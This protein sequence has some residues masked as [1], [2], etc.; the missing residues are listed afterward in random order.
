M[1]TFVRPVLVDTT[2]LVPLA[3]DVN[4][5]VLAPE[6][7]RLVLHHRIVYVPKIRAVVRTGLKQLEQLVLHTILICV[8]LA[9][10]NITTRVTRVLDVNL[11]AREHDKP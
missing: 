8:Q 6:K 7:P 1:P 11:V 5:A 2:K 10:V 4:L 3:L 9:P